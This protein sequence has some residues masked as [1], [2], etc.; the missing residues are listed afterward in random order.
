MLVA[1]FEDSDSPL[2]IEERPRP[3]VSRGEVLI[4]VARCGICSSDLQW[5]SGK[6]APLAPGTVLGHEFSGVVEALGPGVTEV[7][8]GDHVVVMPFSGCDNCRA[9][10]EGNF[11]FC[12]EKRSLWGGFGQF[13]LAA[14]N[15]CVKLEPQVT[16]ENAAL[17]EPFAC[18]ARAVRISGAGQT[19][20]VLVMGAGPIG[21][22]CVMWLAEA[23]VRSI[24]VVARSDRQKD[25]ALAM[26][27]NFF[28]EGG[29]DTVGA[30]EE[31][32]AQPDMIFECS[33]VPG[34][35]MS[36]MTA[37]KPRGTLLVAGMC[38][39]PD[40]ILPSIGLIKELAIQ[41][42]AAYSKDDFARTAAA[43]VAPNRSWMP[44]VEKTIS[45]PE[46]PDMF[47][48]LRRGR[49][50]NKILVDPWA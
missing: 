42:S 38:P 24:T 14:A 26:G 49:K 20:D 41:F 44:M 7:A 28:V 21:L 1:A 32:G 47:Q 27:A 19:T 11:L 35:L 37:I 46:L 40:L 16:W 17:V 12:S 6:G 50:S 15:S 23:N 33:G 18:G 30:I 22:A 4:R 10:R 5:A 45:L 8:V 31:A 36:A 39:H 29:D 48:A 13:T 2:R 34:A 43:L 3:A 9:C 25:L